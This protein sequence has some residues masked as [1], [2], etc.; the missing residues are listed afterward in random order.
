MEI[1]IG[2]SGGKRVD[3]QLDAR[4]G[5]WTIRTD[6][7]PRGGGDGSAPEPFQLFLTSL[8]TCAGVY[9]LGF[10]QARGIPT[11]GIEMT[12]RHDF[13]ESGR[14]SAVHLQI[15]VPDDFPPK[16]VSVL[17]RV[18]AKCTVKRVLESPPRF[19][20]Q[21]QARPAELRRSTG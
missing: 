14:L 6:Q 9:V 7:S 17:E 5:G 8:A 18:A 21:A 2:F 15:S 13:D 4:L 16:Y 19:D 1:R 12:Q 11:E 20:I 10:C 3:A